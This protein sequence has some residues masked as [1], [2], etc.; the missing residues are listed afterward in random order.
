MKLV[1]HIIKKKHKQDQEYKFNV[2]LKRQEYFSKN[3][4]KYFGS[5][6]IPF[7]ESD[8]NY[9]LNSKGVTEF[10]IRP[11]I[12]S[13][14]NLEQK[15]ITSDNMELNNKSLS[16]TYYETVTPELNVPT[17]FEENVLK[18]D[19]YLPPPPVIRTAC[20]RK[21][22]TVSR[23]PSDVTLEMLQQQIQ[24]LDNR[25]DNLEQSIRAEIHA[26][27]D[28]ILAKLEQSMNYERQLFQAISSQFRE[29]TIEVLSKSLQG[30]MVTLSSLSVQSP[31]C[32]Q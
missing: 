7:E 6:N 21:S 13:V 9:L 24:N 5:C 22:A 31:N 19:S 20:K 14:L 18:T 23:P 30:M 32:R 26:A 11:V 1:S 2:Q 12:D 10:D 27:K 15:E 16:S 28:D 29:A 8:I 17:Q 25:I 4:N 3:E